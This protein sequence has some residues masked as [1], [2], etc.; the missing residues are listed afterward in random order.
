METYELADALLEDALKKTSMQDMV[1]TRTAIEAVRRLLKEAITRESLLEGQ[2]TLNTLLGLS[3]SLGQT[4]VLLLDG[5]RSAEIAKIRGV[6]RKT[7]ENQIAI[8]RKELRLCTNF[9]PLALSL[10][11]EDHACLRQAF[12][13]EYSA[14]A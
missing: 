8:L 6:T 9:I 5:R 2:P 12:M 7:S 4:L 10:S 14:R 3:P 13:P 1:A 11:R